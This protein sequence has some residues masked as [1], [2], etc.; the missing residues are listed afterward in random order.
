M[1]NPPSRFSNAAL[2]FWVLLWLLLTVPFIG[3]W[4]FALPI[5]LF[6]WGLWKCNQ[7]DR[8]K[9]RDQDRL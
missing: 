4:S 3:K 7:I 9:L 1:S 6:V 2:L 5:G 8:A